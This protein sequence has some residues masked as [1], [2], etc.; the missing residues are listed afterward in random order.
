M[1]VIAKK[2]EI[3]VSSERKN[4]SYLGEQ[5]KFLFIYGNNHVFREKEFFYPLEH[6]CS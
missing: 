4:L 1:I 2:I 3:Y 6:G 5:F